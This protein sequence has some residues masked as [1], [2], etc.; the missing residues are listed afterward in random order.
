MV[1]WGMV[2][3]MVIWGMVRGMLN[4]ELHAMK[5]SLHATKATTA[6]ETHETNAFKAAVVSSTVSCRSVVAFA[7][8]STAPV[9]LC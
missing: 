2:R 6:H 5:R 9:P 8:F 3:G 1:R 7:L 4:C